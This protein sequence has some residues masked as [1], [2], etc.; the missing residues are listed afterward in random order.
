MFSVD[1][2][3]LSTVGFLELIAQFIAQ[4]IS[5]SAAEKQA[6]LVWL[7]KKKRLWYEAGHSNCTLWLSYLTSLNRRF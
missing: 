3:I 7:N 4:E 2:I 5:L 1:I 6:L